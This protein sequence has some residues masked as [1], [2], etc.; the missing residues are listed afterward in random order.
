MIL[1]VMIKIATT[2]WGVLECDLLRNIHNTIKVTA[3]KQALITQSAVVK[4][5]RMVQK[6]QSSGPKRK[7][8]SIKWLS[9]YSQQP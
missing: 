6:H 1:K 9:K 2:D 5:H 4:S 3:I 7:I 8:Q